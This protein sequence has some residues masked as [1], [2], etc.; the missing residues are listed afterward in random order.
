MPRAE[1]RA[2]ITTPHEVP[3]DLAILAGRLAARGVGVRLPRP[4]AAYVP[5]EPLP[6]SAGEPLSDVVLRLRGRL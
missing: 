1:K 4:A 3:E 6:L 5:P 2:M